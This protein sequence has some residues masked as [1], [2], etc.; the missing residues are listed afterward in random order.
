MIFK[1]YNLLFVFAFF[2]IGYNNPPFSGISNLNGGIL[3]GGFALFLSLIS[4]RVKKSEQKYIWSV[5]F[6]SIIFLIIGIVFFEV[7]S[8]IGFTFL[9]IIFF[10]T[11]FLL[12]LPIGGVFVGL[13]KP[14]LF[15][16]K[17]I[18]E[19]FKGINIQNNSYLLDTS[20]IIDGRITSIIT[21]GF[22]EGEFIITQFVLS[23]LQGIADSK[24]TNKRR[25]GK[26]GLG[27]IEELRKDKSIILKIV[28]KDVV[29]PKEVD[30]KLIVLARDSNYKIITNDINLSKVAR[31]Q[32]IK[33][34]NINELAHSIKP[35]VYPGESFK[36]IIIKEGKEKR[37]G[38]A[39]LED[40][41]MVIID[42]AKD[43]IGTEITVEITSVL[44][45][46]TGKMFF[47]K[48]K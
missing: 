40:G 20:V 34:L 36:I 28:N 14:E 16:P 24:D 37:Q 26:R 19:F 12:G 23:E 27:V 11:F 45:S 9:N 47:G 39:Y 35:V 48:K 30:H 1:I 29:G 15:A 38:I 13:Y 8:S 42:D 33:V 2:I 10:K 43:D 41:T 3:G 4:L 5:L 18:K 31:L 32:D 17:N 21:S 46:T 44:Q 22:I 7:F 6:S 25:R